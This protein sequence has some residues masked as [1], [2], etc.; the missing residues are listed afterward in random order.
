[1]LDVRRRAFITLLGGGAVLWPLACL[2]Q[3]SKVP[4]IGA[5]V[6][7]NIS[8]VSAGTNTRDDLLFFQYPLD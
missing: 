7:G 1:M 2:A 6:I 5:L 8:R 3:Q 4:T